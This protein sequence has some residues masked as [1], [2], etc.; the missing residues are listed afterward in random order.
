MREGSGL[1]VI[2]EVELSGEVSGCHSFMFALPRYFTITI[3]TRIEVAA[4]SDITSGVIRFSLGLALFFALPR[5]YRIPVAV[6][7][8]APSAAGIR[9][10][11]V[12]I[13]TR[14]DRIVCPADHRTI[15]SDI[16]CAVP[17]CRGSIPRSRP[18]YCCHM[19]GWT[20][21]RLRAATE[22]PHSA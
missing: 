8:L 3:P 1:W 20:Q 15:L 11:D 22:L 4:T 18:T 9:S 14:I 16:G 17:S 21:S 19:S 12:A 13:V 10:V 6:V 2:S 5:S 7:V